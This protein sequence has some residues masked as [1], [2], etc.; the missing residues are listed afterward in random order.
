M[1]A[2]K[3]SPILGQSVVVE[4]R[5]GASGLIAGEALLGLVFQAVGDVF[6]RVTGLAAGGVEHLFA[7]QDLG[8]VDVAPFG[9]AEVAGVEGDEV[10]GGAVDLEPAA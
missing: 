4:N 8:G 7:A 6:R 1:F 2:E 9:D 5:G 3:M 10:E